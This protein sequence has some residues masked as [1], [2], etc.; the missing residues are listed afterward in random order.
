MQTAM[1]AIFLAIID[2]DL[3][4]DNKYET[5]DKILYVRV[6]VMIFSLA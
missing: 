4:Y 3:Y 5:D 6:L 1:V 2:N